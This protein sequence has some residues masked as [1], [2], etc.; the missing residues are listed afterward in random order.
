M[1]TFQKV[2]FTDGSGRLY[3]FTQYA[4]NTELK[5]FDVDLVNSSEDNTAPM[6]LVVHESSVS[7]PTFGR[8]GK[9]SYEVLPGW[10]NGSAFTVTL[11]G[12]SNKHHVEFDR[13]GNATLV[14]A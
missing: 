13:S 6:V 14:S 10:D 3:V 2:S 7:M 5:A 8:F 11:N 9:A 4:W 12:V 1:A